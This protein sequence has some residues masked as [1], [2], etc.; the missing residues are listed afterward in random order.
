M[1]YYFIYSITNK[2]EK[3]CKQMRVIGYS[4]LQSS[5]LVVIVYNNNGS[6]RYRINIMLLLLPT[7]CIQPHR[8]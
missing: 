1:S 7:G 4:Y 3:S 2:P 5:L 8:R 6:S